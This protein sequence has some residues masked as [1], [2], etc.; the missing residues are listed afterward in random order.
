MARQ[1]CHPPHQRVCLL[2]HKYINHLLGA[3]SLG[4]IN[5]QYIDI[6]NTVQSAWPA[7]INSIEIN[8][9]QCVQGQISN[10]H[11]QINELK[12]TLHDAKKSYR[13]AEAALT[14]EHSHVKDLEQELKDLKSCSQP[15]A[16]ASVLLPMT[17]AT[18][19]PKSQ[20][21]VPT[22]SLP[23]PEAG[24]SQLPPPQPE[25]G[26]SS[27]PSSQKETRPAS[28]PEEVN[29]GSCITMKVDDEYDWLTEEA[30]FKPVEGPLP[31]SK[32]QQGKGLDPSVYILSF[33][34]IEALE[35]NYLA[36]SSSH[37]LSDP[38]LHQEREGVL[39]RI[40]IDKLAMKNRVLGPASSI[41]LPPP[42]ETSVGFPWRP[43]P[44]HLANLPGIREP[45]TAGD[46][47]DSFI[48]V[49]SHS[50]FTHYFPS[51]H[52]LV[53]QARYPIICINL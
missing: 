8:A 19:E 18:A 31:V 5:L 21:V 53:S 3:Q 48:S 20:V 11:V 9:D 51:L 35:K 28:P 4:Q 46:C 38:A 23:Q 22:G 15:E 34:S 25:A 43:V 47:H 1:H 37:S 39:N 30:S 27:L 13:N 12:D 42:G 41:E 33:N 45:L 26:P 14:K 40:A 44:E 52:S 32:R 29:L 36:Q 7:F 24:P 16:N 50:T 49:D 6:E 10:L 17:L 2:F